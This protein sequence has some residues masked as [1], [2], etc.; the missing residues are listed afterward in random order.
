MK[1]KLFI[2]LLFIFLCFFML[3]GSV[4][5]VFLFN[6]SK[7]PVDIKLNG[8]KDININVNGLFNNLHSKFAGIKIDEISNMG[9]VTIRLRSLLAMLDGK[10]RSGN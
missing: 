3:F 4:Y 5:I 2:G 6:P 10:K 9:A 1:K 8:S 7:I